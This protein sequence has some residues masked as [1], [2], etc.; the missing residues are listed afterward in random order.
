MIYTS[1]F[2]DKFWLLLCTKKPQ[3]LFFCF[4]FYLRPH[5]SAIFPKFWLYFRTLLQ[6]YSLSKICKLFRLFLIFDSL[7][8]GL[9]FVGVLIWTRLKVNSVLDRETRLSIS[10]PFKF[11]KSIQI[12]WSFP[13]FSNIFILQND[14]F[15]QKIQIQPK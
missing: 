13:R 12:F 3:Y 8:N 14:C 11:S 1:I 9:S 6:K 5:H 7:R 10:K 4:L 15:K 2:R